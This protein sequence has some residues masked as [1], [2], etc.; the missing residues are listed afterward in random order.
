MNGRGGMAKTPRFA[1]TAN[2]P[3]GIN[4]AHPHRINHKCGE[5]DF[6]KTTCGPY[7]CEFPPS[8]HDEAVAMA[9]ENLCFVCYHCKDD[10]CGHC[11]GVPC[12]CP[13]PIPLKDVQPEYYI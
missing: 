6:M 9:R 11:V 8:S 3:S 2:Q 13:C 5:V 12:M 1:Q 7:P 4:P 10:D